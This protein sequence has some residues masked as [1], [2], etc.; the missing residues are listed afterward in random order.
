MQIYITKRI[1]S[2]FLY[3]ENPIYTAFAFIK[4]YLLYLIFLYKIGIKLRQES[5]KKEIPIFY[6]VFDHT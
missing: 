4:M 6:T 3:C 1:F 2:I 5:K